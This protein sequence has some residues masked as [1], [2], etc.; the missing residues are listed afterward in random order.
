VEALRDSV[1]EY[2]AL[3]LSVSLVK[4]TSGQSQHQFAGSEDTLRQTA[5]RIVLVKN[6]IMLMTN[7]NEARHSEL[8]QAVEATYLALAS[9]QP[10]SLTK[11]RADTETITCA[12]RAVLRA[13]WA[14][15][16]RGD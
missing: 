8:C 7:P 11:M 12:G 2:V 3:V 10:D 9:G 1:A 14:K 5:E 15:V 4:Q 13:E 6:R 16:K